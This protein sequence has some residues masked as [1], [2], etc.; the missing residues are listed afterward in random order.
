MKDEGWLWMMAA[1]AM[2][3]GSERRGGWWPVGDSGLWRIVD[4]G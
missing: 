4:D 1:R 3:N 2:G